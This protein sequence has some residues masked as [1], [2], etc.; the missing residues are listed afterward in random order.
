MCCDVLQC[1]AMCCSVHLVRVCDIE[2]LMCVRE[3]GMHMCDAAHIM[4]VCDIE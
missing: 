4:H 2:C 1:I 3:C